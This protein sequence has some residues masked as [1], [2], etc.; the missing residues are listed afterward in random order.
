MLEGY[1]KIKESRGSLVKVFMYN[2]DTKDLKSIIVDDYEYQYGD[3][4][5]D[6]YVDLYGFEYLEKI[7]N[8]PINEK[9]LFK[10]NVDNDIICKGMMIEVVKGRKYKKG[11]RGIVEKIYPYKD[12]YGRWVADYIITDNGMKINM[13]NVEIVK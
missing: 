5:M 3:G 6:K 1:Y 12:K 2:P 9:I 8:E 13:N 11:L 10:Y 7:R 4:F